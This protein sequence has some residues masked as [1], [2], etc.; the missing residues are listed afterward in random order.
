VIKT[1][2]AGFPPRKVI[3]WKRDKWDAYL[4]RKEKK[5]RIF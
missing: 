5:K 2:L 4:I 3:K 1:A